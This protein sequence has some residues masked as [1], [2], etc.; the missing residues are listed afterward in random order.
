MFRPEQTGPSPIGIVVIGAMII[1]IVMIGA[2]TIGIMATAAEGR[3]VQR[4]SPLV[5]R[6]QA[7]WFAVSLGPLARVYFGGYV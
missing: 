5:A 3:A 2:M 7:Q 1:G 6:M 4:S